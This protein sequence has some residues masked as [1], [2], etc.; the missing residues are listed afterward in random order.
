MA[1]QPLDR[2]ANDT[3]SYFPELNP[4]ILTL[5]LPG[6]LALAHMRGPGTT[7]RGAGKVRLTQSHR[8]LNLAPPAI[9][10]RGRA[11]SCNSGPKSR[12]TLLASPHN[13][14][15]EHAIFRVDHSPP[16]SDVFLHLLFTGGRLLPADTPKGQ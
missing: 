5:R 15:S 13:P 12:R 14:F 7:T 16:Q 8:R 10:F 9:T 1:I 3:T 2:G 11:L 6:G 4:A